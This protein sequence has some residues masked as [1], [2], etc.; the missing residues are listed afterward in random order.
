MVA[1]QVF[2]AEEK[3]R[4]RVV[5]G[6]GVGLGVGVLNSGFGVVHAHASGRHECRD[7][8]GPRFRCT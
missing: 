4:S 3:K 2:F 7:V 5:V 1:M 8:R 6:F